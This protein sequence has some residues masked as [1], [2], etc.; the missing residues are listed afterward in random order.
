M[1]ATTRKQ[2]VA[3]VVRA[4]RQAKGWTQ[5]E[6]AEQVH[7]NMQTISHIERAMHLPREDLMARLEAALDADLSAAAA[8]GHAMIDEVA[9]KMSERM[10]ELGMTDGIEYASAVLDLAE[11]WKPRRRLHAVD[12]D[13]PEK[14]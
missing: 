10:R 6:L 14:G 13:G 12:G 3:D 11:S 4:A 8:A 2:Q 5:T 9:A 1:P 7:V